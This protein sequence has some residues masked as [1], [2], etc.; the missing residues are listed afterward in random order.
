MYNTLFDDDIPKNESPLQDVNITTMLL[1]MSE[2]EN[3]EF[4]ALCKE[5]IK[6]L[7]PDDYREK[8]NLT[9]YLLHLIR[10]DNEKIS[11]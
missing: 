5:G 10:K 7:F 4:K 2:E 11:T 3:K 1:Y 6:K 8:G 9:D